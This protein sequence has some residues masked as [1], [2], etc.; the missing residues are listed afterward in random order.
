MYL[1]S[2]LK[3]FLD[4]KNKTRFY[5]IIFL[6]I[7]G[8]LLETVGIGIILPI[9]TF[10]IKGKDFFLDLKFVSDNQILVNYFT[11]KNDKE[12][13]ISSLILISSIFLLKNIFLV[14]LSWTKENFNF[15]LRSNLSTKL[16]SIYLNKD[17]KAFYEK[18]SAQYISLVLNQVSALVDGIAALIFLL[19]EFFIFTCIFILLAI[20]EPEG[21][22]IVLFFLGIAFF[23]TLFKTKKTI[24]K[25]AEVKFRKDQLQIKNLS[26][27][28]SMFKYLKVLSF[29]KF[30]SSNFFANNKQVNDASK[31]QV[32][33]SSLPKQLF[34]LFVVLGLCLLILV[35]ISKNYNTISILPTIGVF[36]VAAARFMPSINRILQSFQTIKFSS[37]AIKV[38]KKEFHSDESQNS[39]KNFHSVKFHNSIELNK[40]N[41]S[42]GK[43]SIFTDLNLKII[44]RDVIGIIGK[45]GI[46]KSTLIDVIMGLSK[47]YRGQILCD[48]YDI[49]EAELFRNIKIGYVPQSIFL[50]DDSVLNNISLGKPAFD[51]KNFQDILSISQLK[52]FVENLPNKQNSI[53]GENGIK[54]SGG[55]KQRIGIA[56]ALYNDPSLL[57]LDEATNALDYE[58]EKEIISAI[59]NSKKNMTIIII[60][61]R[62]SILNYCN[63]VYKISSNNLE[64]Q[65]KENL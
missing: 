30:F 28:F 31:I 45:T 11:L 42:Y 48:G 52:D 27:G 19:N 12:I 17:Y 51:K 46:G 63:K 43:K 37:P 39:K 34:E 6:I 7:I 58:T 4:K 8:T 16:F 9:L 61:H 33:I 2:N 10:I 18:N 23:L 38:L 41:F 64:I 25:W 13:L 20:V 60:T 35:L 65:Q 1:F 21:S 50:M 62:Q 36:V 47:A 15:N 5:F 24:K 55:Q 22:F 49:T 59:V 14:F 56:R 54:I 57:I 53:I 29:E 44:K 3:Y 26:E 40:V 32:F